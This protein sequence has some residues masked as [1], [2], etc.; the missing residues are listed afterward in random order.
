MS[1]NGKDEQSLVLL[2]CPRCKA[3]MDLK[4]LEPFGSRHIIS[5]DGKVIL[6]YYCNNPVCPP[7]EWERKQRLL[8]FSFS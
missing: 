5:D 6:L 3:T 8:P 4:R 7:D 2:S 1:I